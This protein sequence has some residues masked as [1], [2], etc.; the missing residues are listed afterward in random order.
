MMPRMQEEERGK[1]VLIVVAVVL[2]ALA[3]PVALAVSGGWMMWRE[4]RPETKPE[5][6]GLRPSSERS[7]GAALPAPT[8]GADAIVRECA[9]E[10]MELEL[11]RIV[12]LAGGVGGAAS[13]WNDG[14]KVRLVA[15]VPRGS[16]QIFR[17]A[18]TGGM[19][20]MAMASDSAASDA[21]VV[22]EVLVRPVAGTKKKSR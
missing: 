1:K 14:E 9:P 6:E 7:A 2:V 22:V 20:G 19:Y 8:I 10:K 12:R 17:D 16:E 18:V 11:Q 4:S 3:L 21:T 5:P 13:A 15:K